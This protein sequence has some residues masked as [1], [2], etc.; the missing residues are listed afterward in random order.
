[1]EAAC[2]IDFQNIII[3]LPHSLTYPSILFAGTAAVG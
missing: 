3:I 2:M 1:M